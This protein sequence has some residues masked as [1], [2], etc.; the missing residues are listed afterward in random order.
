MVQLHALEHGSTARPTVDIDVLGDSRR[1]PSMTERI[2]SILAKRGAEMAT[3]P[4]GDEKLGFRFD[5]DGE[6]VEVLGSEGLPKDPRTAGKHTTFQVPGGTQA[7]RRTEKVRVSLDGGSAVVLRRPTLLGAV[8]IK[9]RVVAKR[10]R[11][12]F[13]SDRQ[14]LVLLLT[15]IEDPRA[16]ARDE[17]LKK[18]ETRWLR[19]VE[20]LLDF[21]DPMLAERLPD[22]AAARAEQAYRLLIA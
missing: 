19:K 14:D 22:G 6:I 9:A 17:E 7:L 5:I 18:T 20:F 2:A 13:D 15:F 16:L 1:R 8:L 3:P 4:P 12:K 10:R 21:D 11:L